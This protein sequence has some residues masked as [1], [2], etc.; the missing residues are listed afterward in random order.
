MIVP[1]KEYAELFPVFPYLTGCL[2]KEGICRVK[3]D[4]GIKNCVFIDGE[5]AVAK[6]WDNTYPVRCKIV[7]VVTAP[8]ADVV[9]E[10]GTAHL[11]GG[12][13][14]WL[15]RI[16]L[17]NGATIYGYSCWWVAIV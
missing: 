11:I 13:D 4:S 17:D 16:N 1:L 7:S 15:V 12:E 5:W 3:L 6:E 10:M 8:D 14:S 9:G 2:E